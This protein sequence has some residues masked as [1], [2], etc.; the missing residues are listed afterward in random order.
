MSIDETK[1]PPL[2]QRGY[3]VTEPVSSVLLITLDKQ[4]DLMPKADRWAG[5]LVD[6]CSGPYT[7]VEIDVGKFVS[8]SSTIIAGLVHLYDGL[9][10]NEKVVLINSNERIQRSIEMMHLHTLVSW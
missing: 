10:P 7:R 5:H 8:I 4:F 9:S 1:L 2:E 3:V 6:A